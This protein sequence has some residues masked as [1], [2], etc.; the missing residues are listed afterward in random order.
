MNILK[1]NRL[2]IFYCCAPTPACD[3]PL[4]WLLPFPICF[5]RFWINTK[6]PVIIPATKQ[7]TD[8]GANC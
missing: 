5:K 3:G 4:L 1:I 2:L 6:V 8:I 7:K